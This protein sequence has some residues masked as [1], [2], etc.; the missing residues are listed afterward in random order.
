MSDV[1]RKNTKDEN[2]TSTNTKTYSKT[3]ILSKKDLTIDIQL[4]KDVKHVQQKRRPVPI[5]FQKIVREQEKLI[6]K[7]HLKKADKTTENCFISPA[8]IT[9]KKDKPVKIALHSRKLNEACVKKAARLNMEELISKI[10]AEITKNDI[11]V[12]MPKIDLDSAYGRAKLSEEAA[13]HCVFS[14]IGDFTGHYR[15]KKSFYG[16]SDIPTVLQEHIDTVQEFKTPVW[17]DDI[18]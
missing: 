8:V 18:I 15:F 1:E 17:L 10:S 12:W 3:I 2:E 14:I 7:G 4:K 6:E 9:I 13:K 11:D 16:L 5:H